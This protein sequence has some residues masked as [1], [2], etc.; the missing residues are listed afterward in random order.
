MEMGFVREFPQIKSVL[1]VGYPGEN[2]NQAAASILAGTVNPSGRT[3]DTWVTDNLSAPASNNFRELQTDG[4][5]AENSFH[6]NNVSD[7]PEVSE[8]LKA[9]GEDTTIR[10]YFNYYAEGIYVGYKYYETRNDTDPGYNYVGDVV[11]PFGH[12]LSYTTFNKKITSLDEKDG[13]ITVCIEVKNTGSMAGKDVLEIYYNPPYTGAIEKATV[14]LVAF[15]KTDLIQPGQ[16]EFYTVQFN[17][18]DMASYDYKVNKAYMMEKGDYII[19]LRSDAHTVICEETWTLDHDFIYDDTHDGARSSDVQ[20]ATNQFDQALGQDDYLTRDWDRTGRAYTGP[21]EEDYTAPQSVI[22]ALTWSNPSD[23]E[24]GLAE[25]PDVGVKLEE[26]IMLADM[27]GVPKDDPK[28]DAFISQLTVDEMATLCDSGGYGI[29]AI[30]RLGVPSLAT[31]D[32]PSGMMSNIYSGLMMGI[33]KSGITYPTE[34]VLASTWSKELA[35]QMGT[36][37]GTEAQALGYSGWYAP[38]MNTHRTPFSG[39]NFEYYSEDGVLAGEIG[40]SVV[41]GATEKGI[42][43]YIKHFALNEREAENRQSLFTWSNEQAIREIY[44]KPFEIAIKKGGALGVMSSFNYIGHEWAGGCEALLTQVL[45]NEWDFEGVVITDS[46][47]YSYMRLDQMLYAGGDL[48][49]DVMTAFNAPGSEVQKNQIMDAAQNPDTQ[50]GMILHLQR[51]S[52]DILYAVANTWKV[53]G[54]N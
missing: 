6:Y 5:W 3:V 45:R 9:M 38:A 28:W 17:I 10:G 2:G 27:V 36:A 32:G 47:R 21:L 49:L 44:L 33:G 4:T 25:M 50:I 13:I 29:G 11:Y 31:P 14:N 34:V 22:D 8:V 19:S 42:I 15:Q 16:T 46:N 30:N 1:W 23:A 54:A 37:V 35:E 26:P 12:G 20:A 40:G 43:C 52:K 39:R 41:K 51:A 18:E 53:T 7:N 48:S 24:Q